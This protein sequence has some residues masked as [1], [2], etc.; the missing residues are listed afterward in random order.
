MPKRKWLVFSQKGERRGPGNLSLTIRAMGEGVLTKACRVALGN[1]STVSF[2]FAP[3][4]T[5]FAIVA[6]PRPGASVYKLN[7]TGVVSMRGLIRLLGI[8]LP[9]TLPAKLEDGM[10]VFEV[11]RA[12][13]KEATDA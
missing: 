5:A 10:L 11:P 3:D 13:L 12:A 8:R 9:V 4:H 2:L 7:D 1:P 6:P